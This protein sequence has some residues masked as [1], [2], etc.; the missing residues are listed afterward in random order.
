MLKPG[1]GMI[2]LF[3]VAMACVNWWSLGSFAQSYPVK[4]IRLIVGYSPGGGTD[5][6][7]RAVAQKLTESL[8]QTVVVENR[9]GATGAIAAE[10]VATS[11]ADGYTLL[12]NSANDMIL[13]AVRS[14]LPFNVERDFAPVSLVVIAPMAII[15]HPSV[16]AQNVKQLL[17]L[18]RSRPGKLSFGSAGTG[19][20]THLAGELFK[21]M[22]KVNIIHVPYKG[23]SD[24]LIA[25]AAGQLE[26]SIASVAAATPMLKVGKLRALAVTSAKRVSSVP[27]LPTLGESGLPGFDYASWF[28]VAAPAGVPKDIIAR[29]NTEIGKAVNTPEMKEWFSKLGLEVETNTPEEFSTFIHSEIVKN[30]K[31]VEFAGV[32]PD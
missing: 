8:G 28:G 4:P 5:V 31:L 6:S 27:A 1:R 3:A 23:A 10:R 30:A 2:L 14:K 7:A 15:V 32:K 25:T 11:P 16:P 21:F 26:M 29:L 17:A 24:H 12:M 22:A 19:N 13:P 9:P 20:T 18:A